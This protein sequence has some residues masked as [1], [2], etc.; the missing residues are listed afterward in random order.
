MLELM[1]QLAQL[2]QRQ[3]RLL[4][5]LACSAFLKFEDFPHLGCVPPKD[6][7]HGRKD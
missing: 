1:K 2:Q 4:T 6:L 3:P 5:S 7:R